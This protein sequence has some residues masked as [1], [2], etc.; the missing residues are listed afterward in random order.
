MKKPVWMIGFVLLLM[1]CNNSADNT[2]SNDT[3]Q[4]NEQEEIEEA[5][6]LQE[7]FPDLYAYLKKQDTSLDIDKFNDGGI[8]AVTDLAA[9]P[10]DEKTKSFS[11]YFICNAD[12]SLAIDLYSYNY[13]QRQKEGKNVLQM[14]GP[15]SEVGLINFKNNTRQRVFFSGPSV[16]VLDAKWTGPEAILIAGAEEIGNEKIKPILWK[17]DLSDSTQH[18]FSYGDTLSAKVYTYTEEKLQE[19]EN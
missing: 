18:S 19:R 12:S 5:T 16:L 3:L 17:I 14:A 13:M 9:V 4:N 15:D 7:S 10:V 1:A 2:V 11:P 8:A 6:H